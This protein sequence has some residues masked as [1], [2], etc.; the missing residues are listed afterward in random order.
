MFEAPLEFT[1]PSKEASRDATDAPCDEHS[2][3][4]STVIVLPA[5]K[6]QLTELPA[7]EL[8]AI[9][10][11]AIDPAVSNLTG[12]PVSSNQP[13]KV[14][15]P[16]KAI[17]KSKAIAT[18][19]GSKL[20]RARSAK[21]PSKTLPP[22]KAKTDKLKPDSLSGSSKQKSSV[23]KKASI[24]AKSPEGAAAAQAKVRKAVQFLDGPIKPRF[25]DRTEPVKTKSLSS[26][27][28][29]KHTWVAL[30][31]TLPCRGT[32][33]ARGFG[34]IFRA[35]GPRTVAVRPKV[36]MRFKS[37]QEY[38]KRRREEA[39]ARDEHPSLG[40]L[41]YGNADFKIALQVTGVITEDDIGV[42]KPL[43]EL[44]GCLV[45]L[46]PRT[47]L[48]FGGFQDPLGRAFAKANVPC[49]L[50]EAYKDPT[51]CADRF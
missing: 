34:T 22:T 42:A 5:T 45:G 51:G 29:V 13:T 36:L 28:I 24:V 33:K 3:D 39:L 32:P 26:Q 6:L 10:L 46:Q 25:Y 37:V 14:A 12:T 8:P 18:K 7:I 4:E 17:G 47:M 41:E 48:W 50:A 11:L 44:S 1:W 49:K 21:A 35:A 43:A 27:P 30:K 9:E 40:Q 15:V 20:S 19:V 16:S 23:L 31:G 38:E 2:E